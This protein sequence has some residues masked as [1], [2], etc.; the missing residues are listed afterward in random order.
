M[1]HLRQRQGQTFYLM[2]WVHTLN[3]SAV[4][5]ILGSWI[6]YASSKYIEK[7]VWNKA[8]TIITRLGSSIFNGGIKYYA[9][10]KGKEKNTEPKT[11]RSIYPS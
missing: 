9:E 7:G 2:C 4:T 8:H 3:D 11:L 6:K 5:Y 1:K 10:E